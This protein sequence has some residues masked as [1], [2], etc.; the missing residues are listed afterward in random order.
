MIAFTLAA[1]LLAAAPRTA[2]AADPAPLTLD[3]AYAA[4]LARSEEIVIK[5][6]TYDQV[7][8]QVDGLWAEV[9]P[10]IGLNADHIWQDTPGHGV[11]FPLPANQNTVAVNGHQPLF[12]GLREYLAVRSAKMQGEA[13]EFAL[14]RAKQLLYQ[15]V[16]GAYLNLLQDHRQIATLEAQVKLTDDRVKELRNFVD[17]G[18][19][20]RSEILAAQSQQAQD[21]AD[22]ESARGRERISQA[23]LQF[24]TGLDRPLDPAEVES[25]ADA[26]DEA[27]FLE[28]AAARPDVEA[29]R[30]DFQSA[31]LFVSIQRRQYWPTISLD[32]NYYLLR[33][34]N[35]SKNVHWDATVSGTLP[36]YY[37][38]QIGA[39]VREAKAGRDIKEAALSLALRRARLEVRSAHSD[40]ASDL[41]VVKA[42]RSALSLAEANSKA[43]I[44]D[45]RHGLVTNI[46]VLTSLTVAENTR[47]RL[48]Q[49]ELQAFDARVRL[50][51]AAGGPGSVK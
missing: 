22:L 51:V 17:I 44:E 18:R 4:A 42:L 21:L 50:E 34:N 19:S 6:R 14:R 38:G 29:A 41:S 12:S 15:D 2:C 16:A 36:L 45:Y 1:A 49:A 10:R 35:Y 5:G 24:L 48:D 40:L 27:P 7:M 30:R 47:L 33:P 23:T 32:G 43:Q 25:P 39:S 26:G 46:D 28:R 13:A 20:R 8:A 31:D 11:N 9:K 3:S 37:G